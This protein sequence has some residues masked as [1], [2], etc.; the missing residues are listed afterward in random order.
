[1]QLKTVGY[2]IAA[3]KPLP[4]C[5]KHRIFQCKECGETFSE[6]RDTVFH[7]FR[8]LKVRKSQG[9]NY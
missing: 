9:L 8:N 5:G 3:E 6:K 2:P 4:Q 1:M 7:D